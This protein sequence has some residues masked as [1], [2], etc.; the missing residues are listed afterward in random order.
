[1]AMSMRDMYYSS[2]EP[3]WLVNHARHAPRYSETHRMMPY[4]ASQTRQGAPVL[5]LFVPM[6]CTKCEEKV[7]EELLELRGVHN[8]MIDPQLQKVIVSGFVD[9]LRALKKV[10]KVKKKSEIWSPLYNGAASYGGG[11][12]YGRQYLLGEKMHHDFD[13]GVYRTSYNRYTPTYGGTHSSY[14]YP[15]SRPSYYREAYDS[16]IITNPSY[17]KHI[18]SDAY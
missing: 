10:K 8:V 4:Y 11:S 7:R 14:Y 15:S 3:T 17:M 12:S 6:C 13:R 5:E 16:H 1:M 2:S 9:P 18:E